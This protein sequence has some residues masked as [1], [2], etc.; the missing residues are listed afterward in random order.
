MHIILGC[1]Y[2]VIALICMCIAIIVFGDDPAFKIGKGVSFIVAIVFFILAAIPLATWYLIIKPEQHFYPTSKYRPS[3]KTTTMNNQTDTTYV[4]TEIKID[5]KTKEQIIEWLDKQ[6]WKGE[7]YEAVFQQLPTKIDYNINFLSTA[8]EWSKTAQG[9]VIWAGRAN[10][11]RNWYNP[12][13]KP[14][15]WEEYCK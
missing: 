11:Y 7:F 5:M 14:M 3:I 12:D 4:I 1:I 9:V 13:N 6:P 15:S 2:I 10:E 8:F